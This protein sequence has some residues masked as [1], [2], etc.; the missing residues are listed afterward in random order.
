[1]INNQVLLIIFIILVA[2]IIVV[3]YHMYRDSNKS[4]KKVH[5]HDHVE[6]RLYKVD[7]TRSPEIEPIWL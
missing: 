2:I 1:M 7:N 3:I 5:F 4:N 6:K